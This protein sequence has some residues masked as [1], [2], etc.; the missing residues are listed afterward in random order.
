MDGDL[1]LGAVT[2]QMLV[3]RVVQHL[4]DAVVQTALVGSPMYM[5]GRLRT[6]SSPSSLSIFEA[7]YFSDF[8]E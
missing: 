6:A 7:S 8:G 4:E 5:P 1:D 2:G 3:D